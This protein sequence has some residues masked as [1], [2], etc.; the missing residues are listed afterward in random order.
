MGT[1]TL[2]HL[3]LFSLFTSYQYFAVHKNI[4]NTS[5]ITQTTEKLLRYLSL[6]LKKMTATKTCRI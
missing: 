3:I 4:Y 6:I 1:N 5:F 2:C